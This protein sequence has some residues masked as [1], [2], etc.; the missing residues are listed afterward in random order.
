MTN[1]QSVSWKDIEE[2]FNQWRFNMYSSVVFYTVFFLV[3]KWVIDY[4]IK[5]YISKWLSQG[6]TLF[7]LIVALI[8]GFLFVLDGIITSYLK[9]PLQL[10]SIEITKSELTKQAKQKL[11]QQ[12]QE[13]NEMF[14][15]TFKKF[16]ILAFP[17]MLVKLINHE[18]LSVVNQQGQV[19]GKVLRHS[20]NNSESPWF[21]LC[22]FVPF[23]FATW[24]IYQTS[25]QISPISRQ[26][27]APKVSEKEKFV[28]AINL[29]NES[30]TEPHYQPN[31]PI[32]TSHE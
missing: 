23:V 29:L 22:Y 2:K 24:L 14:K 30:Q 4:G 7:T 26:Y 32:E 18:Q 27:S 15:E 21:Y 13:A 8:L 19:I 10:L 1:K 28:K 5:P 31:L 9:T 12:T 11:V 25:Q 20:T 16:G 3:S 17:T 6:E